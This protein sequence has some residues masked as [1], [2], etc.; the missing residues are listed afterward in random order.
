MAPDLPNRLKAAYDRCKNFPEQSHNPDGS[1]T[2]KG[3]AFI[4]LLDLRALVPEIGLALHQLQE[5]RL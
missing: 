5:S 2:V 1:V 4:A 3:D